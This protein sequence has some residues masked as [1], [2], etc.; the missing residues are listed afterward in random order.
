MLND[1]FD[2][3]W[4]QLS[5]LSFWPSS[6]L[7]RPRET[8]KTCEGKRYPRPDLNPGPPEYK[9]VVLITHLLCLVTNGAGITHSFRVGIETPPWGQLRSKPHLLWRMLRALCYRS[10]LIYVR[11]CVQGQRIH[12]CVQFRTGNLVN[13]NRNCYISTFDARTLTGLYPRTGR[14]WAVSLCAAEVLSGLSNRKLWIIVC[15]LTTPKRDRWQGMR[16]DSLSGD[17]G[18]WVAWWFSASLLGVLQF[19]SVWLSY[20]KSFVGEENC[21]N[22]FLGLSLINSFSILVLLSSVLLG[23]DI[24]GFLQFLF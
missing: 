24:R 17:S 1:E 10:C 18:P 2:T 19:I 8:T 21:V 16:G 20:G 6:C 11:Y 13:V 9:A 22:W 12:S 7:E 4:K 15:R 23:Q 14:E 3:S 5:T